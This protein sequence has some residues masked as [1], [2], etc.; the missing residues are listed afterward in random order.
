MTWTPR[1]VALVAKSVRNAIGLQRWSRKEDF[2]QRSFLLS[3]YVANR[4]ADADAT[5]SSQLTGV[6]E[7][8][9]VGPWSKRMSPVSKEQTMLRYSPKG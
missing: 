6:R 9:V 2:A 4:L 8:S 3:T 1:S 5:F 7:A